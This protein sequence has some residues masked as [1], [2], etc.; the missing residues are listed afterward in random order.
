V[1]AVCLSEERNSDLILDES[2]EAEKRDSECAPDSKKCGGHR[3]GQIVAQPRSGALEKALLLE[4]FVLRPSSEK[5]RAHDCGEGSSEDLTTPGTFE[6]DLLI[7][8]MENHARSPQS[9]GRQRS[10][11]RL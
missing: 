5:M 4:M 8:S 9:C 10:S 11:A 1:Q 3:F 6:F 2:A 7:F